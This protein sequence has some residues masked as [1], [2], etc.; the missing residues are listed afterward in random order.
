MKT[1]HEKFMRQALALAEKGE[2]K[3]SPNPMVGAVVVKNHKIIG[4][5]YH[6]KFGGPHAEVFALKEA[7]EKAKGATL[8]VTL[9]PCYHHGKTPPCVEAVIESGVKRVVI[10]MKDPNPLTAGK[11]IRKLTANKI[12]VLLGVCKK[13][14]QELNISFIHAL[15]H[16]RPYIVVKVA[17]S[18]DGMITTHKGQQGWITGQQSKKFVQDLRKKMDGVLVGSGTLTIDD[19]LLNVR[20]LKS[21]QPTRIILSQSL[22]VSPSA[23]VLKS[24]G[25]KV[26]FFTS[27]ESFKNS[28][29]KLLSHQNVEIITVGKKGN[30]LD[31]SEVMDELYQR[32]IHRLLVEG[33]QKVFSS[34]ADADMADEYLFLVAPKIVGSKGLSAFSGISKSFKIL[35]EIRNIGDD[36]LLRFVK[37]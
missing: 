8:Y 2:G 23:A 20:N 4:Q 11:S 28:N 31:L 1:V 35:K 15:K 33:G 34:F 22:K 9:E 27:R 24:V 3:V 6:K 5:G 17:Q 10:A 19:P 14:A 37:K 21:K 26:I 25:G 13:N 29:K 16:K 36:L 32:G 12:D 18:L 7:G 30:L